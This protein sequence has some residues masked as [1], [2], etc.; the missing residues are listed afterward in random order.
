MT[1]RGVVSSS[2]WGKVV[3]VEGLC[4]RSAVTAKKFSEHH[5]GLVRGEVVEVERPCCAGLV[6]SREV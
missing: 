5:R 1:H 3:E 6:S 2:E 4:Y